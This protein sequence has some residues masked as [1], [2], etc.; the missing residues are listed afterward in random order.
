MGYGRCKEL[1]TCA[2]MRPEREK[3]DAFVRQMLLVCLGSVH[4]DARFNKIAPR[5]TRGMRGLC[6]IK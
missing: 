1:G 2:Q 4:V 6:Q 5:L 3:V